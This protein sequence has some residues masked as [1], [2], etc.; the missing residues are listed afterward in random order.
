MRFAWRYVVMSAFIFWLGGFTFYISIVVPAGTKV[1]ED[2]L[3]RR[4]AGQIDDFLAW[5]DGA[6]VQHIAFLTHDIV[7]AVRTFADRGVGFAETP[8]R[9][10]S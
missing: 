8:S 3:A 5:H 10:F 9:R 1:Q 7:H 6:G 4:Q 2:A